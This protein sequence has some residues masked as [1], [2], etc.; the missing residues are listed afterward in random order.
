MTDTISITKHVNGAMRRAEVDGTISI[1]T[2]PKGHEILTHSID[3]E[4]KV[5]VYDDQT[6]KARTIYPSGEIRA[7]GG[8]A[9]SERILYVIQTDGTIDFCHGE[10][11]SE[12]IAR[13]VFPDGTARVHEN[14]P[15]VA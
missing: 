2:G 11:G 14:G 6:R 4:G 12:R 9:G 13:T 10:E 15:H 1:F 5:T 7:Y 8:Y 3:P